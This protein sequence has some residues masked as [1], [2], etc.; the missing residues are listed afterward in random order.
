M[1]MIT[2][3]T[4]TVIS[5]MLH[6]A[7]AAE[8]SFAFAQNANGQWTYEKQNSDQ[9][10]AAAIVHC[11]EK[12]PRIEITWYSES[13]DWTAYD[14]YLPGT[15]SYFE[16]KIKFAQFPITVTV[17]KSN[18]DSPAVTSFETTSGDSGQLQELI[19][20][21]P[22]VTFESAKEFPFKLPKC[23]ENAFPVANR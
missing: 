6:T 9:N 10:L 17:K 8:T 18:F 22:V 4:L 15:D 11:G 12:N 7:C 14:K 16:R 5:L 20:L 19:E 13:G 21:P 2:S 3:A 23:A 1:K